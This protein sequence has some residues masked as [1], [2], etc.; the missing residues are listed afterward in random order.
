MDKKQ[1]SEKLVGKMK[2]FIKLASLRKKRKEQKQ[3]ATRDVS[4]LSK[5]REALGGREEEAMDVDMDSSENVMRD[6]FV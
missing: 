5:E 2:M 3:M 1:G 6:R 4:S